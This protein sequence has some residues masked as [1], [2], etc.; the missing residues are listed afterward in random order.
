MISKI[1]EIRE[2]TLRLSETKG[3]KLRVVVA[4]V[5]IKVMQICLLHSFLLL[6]HHR[7]YRVWIAFA[8]TSV[9][10]CYHSS[11]VPLSSSSFKIDVELLGGCFCT[12]MCVFQYVSACGCTLVSRKSKRTTM[13]ANHGGY[14]HCFLFQPPPATMWWWLCV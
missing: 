7:R 10:S 11:I 8:T 3:A 5:P 6:F 12:C 2:T 13:A 9:V 14:R 1:D 4:S